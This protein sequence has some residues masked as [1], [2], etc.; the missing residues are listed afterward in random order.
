[1]KGTFII[2]KNETLY[3]IRNN[4]NK[5]NIRGSKNEVINNNFKITD[6]YING[7]KNIIKVERSGIINCIKI[8][9]NNNKI[10]INN[11]SFTRFIDFGEGNEFKR[12]C[13]CFV[14]NN[15]LEHNSNTNAHLRLRRYRI[16]R[17]NS[18]SSRSLSSSSSRSIHNNPVNNNEQVVNERSAI[19]E[20]EEHNPEPNRE[21]E[22]EVE[23]IEE[24]GLENEF[25]NN[26]EIFE[27]KN[28]EKLDEEKKNCSICLGY[29]TNGDKAIALPCMHIFHADCIK[30]WV[31]KRGICPTCKHE[32]KHEYYYVE[33]DDF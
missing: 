13:R 6:L 3:K 11:K 15:R 22:S 26:M 32:I 28:V 7:N 17:S 30:T 19:H 27:I 5:V 29:Y 21:L 14:P 20:E 1:M 2:G 8:F 9:G 18:R 10:L 23:N 16:N 24:K 31:S 12:N 25:M 4:L 33:N